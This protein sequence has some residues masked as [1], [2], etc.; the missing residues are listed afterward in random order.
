VIALSPTVGALI[1]PVS[2]TWSNYIVVG[3]EHSFVN[4][5]DGKGYGHNRSLPTKKPI[6]T[7]F[8]RMKRGGR[9]HSPRTLLAALTTLKRTV[10]AIGYIFKPHSGLVA[11]AA[12]DAQVPNLPW[13]LNYHQHDGVVMTPREFKKMWKTISAIEAGPLTTEGMLSA[14]THVSNNQPTDVTAQGLVLTMSF[15]TTTPERDS[16]SFL[17]LCAEFLDFEHTKLGTDIEIL[18]VTAHVDNMTASAFG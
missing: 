10:R 12:H 13:N 5:P 16:V 11:A 7:S 3:P 4:P 8:Y 6:L 9:D 2:T 17:V 15:P 18:M 14:A 1:A